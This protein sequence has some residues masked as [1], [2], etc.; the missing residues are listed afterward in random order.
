MTGAT[1]PEH[2][3]FLRRGDTRPH[4]TDEGTNTWT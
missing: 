1:R 3:R 2:G 4:T